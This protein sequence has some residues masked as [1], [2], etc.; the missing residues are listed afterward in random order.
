VFVADP[1]AFECFYR[2]HVE[3]VQRFI[4]R[5]VTSPETAADLTADVF[6]AA[7]Q[8]AG[9]YDAARG[10]PRAW[11]FGIARHQIADS[12]RAAA[13]HS[14]AQSAVVGSELVDSEDL[15]RIHER[16]DAEAAAR[17]LYA[18]LRSIPE[19]ERAVLELVALDEL[20]VAEAAAALG[21]STVAARVRLHRARRRLTAGEAVT[22]ATGT[23]ANGDLRIT[24]S[25][26]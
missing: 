15:Q 19:A 24:E 22:P 8:A 6:L 26:A 20:T 3:A 12:Y 11:L 13:K 1:E 5:R 7:I 2:E 25:R 14:R 21:I 9:S 4:A 16:L 10:S 23:L 17:A 18:R